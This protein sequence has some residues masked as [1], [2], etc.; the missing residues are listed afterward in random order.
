M[1]AILNYLDQRGDEVSVEEFVDALGVSPSTVR[2]E[3]AELDDMGVLHRTHGGARGKEGAEEVPI[4]LR[5]TQHVAA[6]RRVAR[7]AASLVPT[8]APHAI[9]V[10]GGTTTLEL[11][12]ELRRHKD[13][14]IITNSL[15]IAV[16]AASWPNIR[17]IAT[18]GV[19]RAKSL[20]ATGPLS[21][22][23]FNAMTVGTAFLGADG[24]SAAGGI[25]T[26]NYLEG[27]TSLAITKH[28]Q[29]VVVVADGRKI[30][31]VTLTQIVDI[32]AIT[33]LV[34]D[35]GADPAELEAIRQAGV[36]VHVVDLP[37]HGHP[38]AR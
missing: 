20:E 11:V 7:L 25:T 16:E 30:G 34:T 33:D 24:V 12:R 3:L 31:Q 19:V 18:G 4:P 36:S 5:G 2:R 28:A 15:L 17:T 14:T 23:A 10:N 13:L 29:R 38:D 1:R 22:G 26:Y 35:S 37:H 9:A 8:G 6:K 32:G 21:E 27:R